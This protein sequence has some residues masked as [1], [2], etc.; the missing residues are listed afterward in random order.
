LFDF[1]KDTL[2]PQA[3]PIL[4]KVITVANNNPHWTYVLIG[5]TD[6]TGP[7]AYNMDL[8][9]RRVKTVQNYLI[10]QGIPAN[11]LSIDEKGEGQ[12]IATN[13]TADGRAQN[14]RVEIHIN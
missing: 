11:L 6:S 12:P 10:T 3:Y 8:S 14:R 13:D 1:D 9:K 7:A 4:A 2:Q 5:N